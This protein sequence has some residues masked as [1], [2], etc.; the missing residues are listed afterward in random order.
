MSSAVV[1]QF[2]GL[3]GYVPGILAGMV[4][5]SPRFAEV[6]SHVDRVAA[7]YRLGPVSVPLTDPEGPSLEELAA[8]PGVAACGV[9]LFVVCAVSGVA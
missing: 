5:D 4:A 3:G 1:I 7:G 8:G 2:P 6:L 9:V